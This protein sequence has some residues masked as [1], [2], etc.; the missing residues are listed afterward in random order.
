MSLGGYKDS[1]ALMGMCC[2]GLSLT[3]TQRKKQRRPL[4]PRKLPP[5][6]KHDHRIYNETQLSIYYSGHIL[7]SLISKIQCP[8]E[9]SQPFQ[10]LP[11]G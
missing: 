8:Q 1:F 3:H 4:H 11:D 9:L 5:K 7:S 6:Q 10:I 2:R